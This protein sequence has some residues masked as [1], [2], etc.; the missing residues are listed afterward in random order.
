MALNHFLE[1][2][3]NEPGMNYQKLAVIRAGIEK[4][5]DE[6]VGKHPAGKSLAP[7][8]PKNEPELER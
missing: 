4:A 8:K 3:K 2:R 1:Q 6:K 5:I 7:K